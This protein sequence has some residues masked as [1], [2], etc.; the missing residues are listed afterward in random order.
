MGQQRRQARQIQRS[1][2][3]PGPAA[4]PVDDGPKVMVGQWTG[5]L[6]CALWVASRDNIHDFA[7]WLGVGS[8]TVEGWKDN[9]SILPTPTNQRVLDEALCRLD[10]EAKR[11]FV[12]L[13]AG[14]PAVWVSDSLWL[15][16][17]GANANRRD[18][19]R[20][21]A[22]L[23]APPELIERI[24]VVARRGGP[25]DATVVADHEEFADALARRHRTMRPDVL[26]GQVDRQAEMLLGLLDRPMGVVAR[27]RLEAIAVASH[28]QAGLLSLY[29]CNRT[30]ARRC[31]ALARSVADDSADP[32]LQAQA[33]AVSS[34]MYSAIQTDGRGGDIERALRRKRE[35]VHY[36]RASDPQTL[37]WTQRWLAEELAASGDE[38]GFRLTIQAAQRLAGKPGHQDG[39]GFFPYYLALTPEQENRSSGVGLVWIGR[40]D[41]ALDVLQAALVGGGPGWVAMTLTDIAATRVLQGEPEQACEELAQAFRLARGRGDVMGVARIRG[42]RRRFRPEWADLACVEELNELLRSPA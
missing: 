34:L 7:G 9:P 2:P 40:A 3:D 27:R 37:A 11:K 15:N 19:S 23:L 26:V 42:V 14:N 1:D 22:A 21:A 5:A 18:L 29:L 10:D 32:T 13:T 16:Q 12:I 41:E 20:A 31:F 33:A 38:R 17:N 39:R 35:A 30:A 36:A 24:A 8:S 4:E 6:A 25:V 28:V